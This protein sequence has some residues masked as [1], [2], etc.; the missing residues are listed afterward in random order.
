MGQVG[1][2]NKD[3]AVKSNN[4]KHLKKVEKRVKTPN[5]LSIPHPKPTITITKK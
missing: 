4:L 2:R 5:Y 3:L 1:F